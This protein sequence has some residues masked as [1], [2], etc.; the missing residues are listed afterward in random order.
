[1]N[2]L[3]K[4]VRSFFRAAMDLRI[5]ALALVAGYYAMKLKL[6]ALKERFVGKSCWKID[7]STY[8]GICVNFYV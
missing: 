8:P 3:S 7:R 2:L 6:L 1:M 5:L 4:V